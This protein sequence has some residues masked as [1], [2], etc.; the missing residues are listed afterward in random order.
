[1]LDQIMGDLEAHSER[2]VKRLEDIIGTR[3]RLH[4]E[5]E[6][7]RAELKAAQAI[8]VQAQKTIDRAVQKYTLRAVS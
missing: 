2:I 3:E 8:F 4:V 1:M 5:E 7:L 6:Q